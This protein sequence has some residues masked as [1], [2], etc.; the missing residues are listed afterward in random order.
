MTNRTDKGHPVFAAFYAALG[1]FVDRGW[2][3]R[4][5]PQLLTGT[6]HPVPEIGVGT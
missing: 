4:R 6:F 3:G 1:V 5:R 2:M